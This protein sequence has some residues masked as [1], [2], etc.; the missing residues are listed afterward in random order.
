MLIPRHLASSCRA[1]DLF[2]L[3]AGPAK[4]SAHDRRFGCEVSARLILALMALRPAAGM[5]L[6]GTYRIERV[7]ASRGFGITYAADDVKLN[8]TVALKEYYPADFDERNAAL[9][10][11]P[12][13]RSRAINCRPAWFSVP[14]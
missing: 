1:R 8:T 4:A 2:G 14:R 9:R 10:V 11:R 6:D 12:K 5:L 3:S 13:L 7:I